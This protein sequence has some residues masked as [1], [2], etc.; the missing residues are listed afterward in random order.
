MTQSSTRNLQLIRQPSEAI[1]PLIKAF[2]MDKWT[3]QFAIRSFKVHLQEKASSKKH[4]SPVSDFRAVR[5][6]G[7]GRFKNH[8]VLD[9]LPNSIT[10]SKISCR[11]GAAASSHETPSYVLSDLV[12]TL[13]SCSA[14]IAL[15]T[16]PFKIWFLK[17]RF[18]TASW[19]KNKFFFFC[20]KFF[21]TV[22]I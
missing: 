15:R 4:Q 17:G 16:S 3:R 20:C 1:L 8:V 22:K 10:W 18:F 6:W 12:P 9:F 21:C 7:Q 13:N 11:A 14:S 5:E 2:L 19:L